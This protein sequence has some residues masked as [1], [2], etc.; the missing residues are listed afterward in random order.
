MSSKRSASD[1]TSSPIKKSKLSLGQLK[2][3]HFFVASSST[4]TSIVS[5]GRAIALS[6][7]SV[8]EKDNFSITSNDFRRQSLDL[9]LP[10][11]DAIVEGRITHNNDHLTLEQPGSSYSY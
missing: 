7:K 11:N 2:L 1:N 5:P 8:T 10:N 4:P 3:D 9:E 6:E